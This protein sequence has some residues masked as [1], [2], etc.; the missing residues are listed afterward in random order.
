MTVYVITEPVAA[1]RPH[2]DIEV[3]YATRTLA[4]RA[5]RAEVREEAARCRN[6]HGKCGVIKGSEDFYELRIGGKQGFHLWTRLAI[7]EA[8]TGVQVR[9]LIAKASELR[10]GE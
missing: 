5:L 3:G 1:R 10:E 9:K 4:R 6:R 2:G 7:G 8:P